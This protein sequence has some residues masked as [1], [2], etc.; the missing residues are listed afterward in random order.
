ML[1]IP[2]L[3]TLMR[4]FSTVTRG[5]L[6]PLLEEAVRVHASVLALPSLTLSLVG[7]LIA[8]PPG[9]PI[10]AGLIFPA[11]AAPD[12]TSITPERCAC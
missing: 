9:A 7:C 4:T 1:P 12:P 8:Q 2:L 6:Q 5:G 3:Q 10:L 11:S